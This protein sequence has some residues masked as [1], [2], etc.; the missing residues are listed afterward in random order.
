M[1]ALTD[2]SREHPHLLSAVRPE[3]T[4]GAVHGDAQQALTLLDHLQ[5]HARTDALCVEILEEPR[6]VLE[7]IGDPFDD[8]A[9]ADSK[10]LERPRGRRPRAG[11]RVAVRARLRI[12]EDADEALLHLRRHRVLDTLRLLV[13]LPPPAA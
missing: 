12:A 3:R 5:R 11:H 10:T 1:A 4:R 13:R 8:G 7:L 6:L 2:L 9:L